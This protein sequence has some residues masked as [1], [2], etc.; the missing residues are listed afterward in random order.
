MKGIR[1]TP[2]GWQAYIRVNGRIR[3]KRFP[4]DTTLTRM[5]AWREEQ[6]VRAR[7]GADLPPPDSTLEDDARMY[8]A[9]VR[10]MPTYTWRETDIK[11]WVTVLGPDRDRRG[12]TASEIRT[13][14]ERWR[15]DGYA[16]NTLNHR[17][18]ALMHLF[19]VLDGKSAPNPARDVPRYREPSR[20]PRALPTAAVRALLE[21]MPDSLT[22]ARL[23]LMAWTGWPHAQIRRLTPE[24]IAWNRAVRIAG[25]QKGRG[26]GDQWLPLLP[27]AWAALRR[28]KRAGAWGDF[29]TSSMR[30]SLRLAAT[31]VQKDRTVP[32]VIR[33]TVADVTPYDFRHSFLTMVALSTDNQRAVQVL[34]LHADARTSQRYTEA[35]GDPIARAALLDVRRSLATSATSDWS[36]RVAMG[37]ARTRTARKR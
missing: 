10:S 8:L 14:L 36:G 26:T 4:P 32:K 28:F 34:G 19:T 20:P 33:E 27:Q 13:H 9:Q 25:R 12:I 31:K 5:K 22:K 2:T 21:A 23:E 35:A 30:T 7:L 37:P 17:R 1:R 15:A 24:D 29:S 16:A 18:T 11:R 3:A 6:R